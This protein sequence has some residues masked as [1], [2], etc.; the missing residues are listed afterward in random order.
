MALIAVFRLRNRVIVNINNAVQ[1]PG[2]HLGDL[3]QFPEVKPGAGAVC[4]YKFG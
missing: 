4:I 2:D 3:I 1:V